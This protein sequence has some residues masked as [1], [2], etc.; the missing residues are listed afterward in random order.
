MLITKGSCIYAKSK[1]SKELA[2]CSEDEP[3]LS[4]IFNTFDSFKKY[5]NVCIIYNDLIIIIIIMK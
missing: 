5:Q 3:Q 4:D 1:K 2:D